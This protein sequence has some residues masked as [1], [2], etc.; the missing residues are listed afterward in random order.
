MTLVVSSVSL[1][2]ACSDSSTIGPDPSPSFAKAAATGPAVTAAS[3]AAA[4]QGTT[5]DVQISGSGFD[6]GSTARWL[7][8]G[9][10]DSRVRTNST[11]YVS[12]TLLIA[13]ITIAGDAPSASYDI[14]VTTSSG[15]KGIGTEAFLIVLNA[16]GVTAIDISNGVT[17]GGSFAISQ[18]GLIVGR[19]G[20]TRGWW[21]SP[22]PA[23][24]QIDSGHVSG[25]NSLGDVGSGASVLL[26]NNGAPPFTVVQLPLPAGVSANTV[27]AKD[28]NDSRT[29]V[30]SA[31]Q[32]PYALRWENPYVTPTPLYP[33]N[34]PYPVQSIFPEGINNNGVIAGWLV[35]KVRNNVTKYAPVVWNAGN[36]AVALPVPPEATQATAGNVNDAGVI[37]GHFYTTRGTYPIRWTPNAGGGYDIAT[38][39][40][41]IGGLNGPN[42]IDSCGRI[43]GGSPLGAWVWDPAVGVMMLPSISGFN[44]TG[45]SRSISNSGEVVGSSNSASGNSLVY[46]AT[47]WR[48]LPACAP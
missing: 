21:Q 9:T 19:L 45:W 3:P 42:G 28:I 18:T 33:G 44:R 47:L 7:R 31:S 15:K 41:D 27:V 29:V 25:G 38:L 6:N 35:L 11:R 22:S 36:T 16:D 48:G 34:Q 37:S 32:V 23:Y 20:S 2:L 14:E 24:T 39:N 8:N 13:N 46:H 17:G 12:S 26:T 10:P 40:L 30:A 5:I 4:P 43:S 1:V